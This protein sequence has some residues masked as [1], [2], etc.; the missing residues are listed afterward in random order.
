MSSSCDV[1]TDNTF[2]NASETSPVT[3]GRQRGVE[4]L[5]SL[6]QGVSTLSSCDMGAS[7][8]NVTQKSLVVPS[9]ILNLV[10]Y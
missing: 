8:D 10:G 4:L 7:L 2:S 1:L 9:E 3:F 6:R 5:K